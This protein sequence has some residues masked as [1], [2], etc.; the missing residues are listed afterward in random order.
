MR[1][2]SSRRSFVARAYWTLSAF[3]L[4]ALTAWQFHWPPF[5][6]SFGDMGILQNGGATASTDEQ[7]ISTDE[8]Y[9]SGELDLDIQ[10]AQ[11]ESSRGDET[12]EGSTGSTETEYGAPQR[13]SSNQPWNEPDSE[14]MPGRFTTTANQLPNTIEPRTVSV[15]SPAP[16]E[17][18]P[19]IPLEREPNRNVQFDPSADDGEIV[20]TSGVPT[21]ITTPSLDNP[22][23]SVPGQAD[24]PVPNDIAEQIAGIDNDLEAG[25]IL[26]AHRALSKLYWNEPQ[27]RPAI[28]Q[29]IDETARSIY[30]QPQPHYMPPYEVQ[31]G[32]Q[33][34]EIAK[35]YGTSWEYLARLNRVDPRRLREGQQL[36][37]IKGPFSA[38]VDLDNYE[39]IVHAYGYYVCRYAVGVG[40]DGSSPQGRFSVLKKLT[41]PQYTAPDG[42][43][44]EGDDPANPLGE[45]WVDLGNSYGIH[46]TIE[47]DSVGRAESRGCIRMHNADVEIVYDLL[48]EGSNVIIQP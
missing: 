5:D 47:P 15:E 40:K 23:P 29:R 9:T 7:N 6:G 11:T 8:D 32:D 31:P 14:N 27:H 2:R 13:L 37:V 18:T 44:M 48:T 41:N 4:A 3:G 25:E 12:F 43:V 28:Q 24:I 19:K 34:R 10:V 26:K 1:K 16:P 39:L 46:G 38:I 45:R 33:L 20:Q 36:K 35:Q 21:E 42:S 30:F 22:A 17:A